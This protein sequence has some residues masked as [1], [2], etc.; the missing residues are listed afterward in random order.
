M[1]KLPLKAFVFMTSLTIM[2]LSCTDFDRDNPNDPGGTNYKPPSSSS[3]QLT[4]LNYGGIDYEVV[5]IGTQAWL[6]K[7]LNYNV[8]GSVCYE[9]D[10]ARCNECGR[11]YN[12]QAA[13]LACPPGWHLPSN[14]EWEKLMAFGGSNTYSAV[15]LALPCGFGSPDHY[16]GGIG[17][18][19]GWWSSTENGTNYAY[20]RM[21]DKLGYSDYK[22]YLFSVRCLE[23]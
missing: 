6:A 10:T 12:W 17:Q 5:L 18:A 13:M 16:F 8:V 1:T 22:E 4:S 9:N 23:D 19:G 2:V 14:A 15:F 21:Y 3:S 7:N 11:L 20:S